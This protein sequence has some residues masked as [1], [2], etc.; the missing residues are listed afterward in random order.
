MKAGLVLAAGG[1]GVRGG[2]GGFGWFDV[3]GLGVDF[4]GVGVF[5]V[6]AEPGHFVLEAVFVA[7]F[8]SEV[9]PVVGA[10]LEI[11]SACVAGIGVEDVARLVL[12]E[13][14]GART[15]FTRE[16]LHGVVVID[17]VLGQFLFRRRDLIVVVEVAAKGRYPVEAP[18]HAF[19][20]D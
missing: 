13:D 16:L 20:E 11:S 10:D 5:V 4:V 7:A 18:A 3:V 19:L 17:Y 6:V 2:A 8:G 9:H 1:L 14:A 12:V 15:F